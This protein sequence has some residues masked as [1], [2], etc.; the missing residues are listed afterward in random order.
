MIDSKYDEVV[1]PGSIER[2]II[3]SSDV[4]HLLYRNRNRNHSNLYSTVRYPESTFVVRL[5]HGATLAY[6]GS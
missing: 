1:Q 2:G 4:V 3:F 6:R 5:S